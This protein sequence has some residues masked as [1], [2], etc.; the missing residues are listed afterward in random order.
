MSIILLI[1]AAWLVLVL[2]ACMFVAGAA[3]RDSHRTRALAASRRHTADRH[4]VTDGGTRTRTDN[5]FGR[6]WAQGK[7]G[8]GRRKTMTSTT[9]TVKRK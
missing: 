7:G 1:L 5:A 4:S 2:A 9:A 3:R 6:K 8:G